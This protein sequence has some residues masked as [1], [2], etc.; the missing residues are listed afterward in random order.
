MLAIRREFCYNAYSTVMLKG[1]N[2]MPTVD[3]ENRSVDGQPAYE[4]PPR[5]PGYEIFKR[6]FDLILSVLALIVLSP[7][8]LG[9]R[10][11]SPYRYRPPGQP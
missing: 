2:G 10:S 4:A 7:V 3:K 9:T 8:F 1:E 11:Y 6:I 5:K